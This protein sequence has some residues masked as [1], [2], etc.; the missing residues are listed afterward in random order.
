MEQTRTAS[1]DETWRRALVLGVMY[2]VVA[3]FANQLV[4]PPHPS[5][6]L[7]LPSG[8]ALAFLL[9][10]PPRR[11]PALLATVFVAEVASVLVHGFPLPF[12]VSGLWGLANC[13]RALT[14]AWLMRRFVGPDIRLSHR[15]EIAGLLF[16]GGLVS[17]LI[18]ATVGSFGYLFSIEPSSFWADWVNW[19]LSDGLGTIL[20]APLLLTWTPTALRSKR[21][22]CFVELGGLLGLTALGAH[23]L[24]GHATV[25][26]VWASMAYASFPFVLWG[27]LRMGPLG[28][29]STSAVVALFALWHTT[30]GQ[31]PF[32]TLVASLQ[33]RISSLQAFLAILGLTALTLA[34]VVSERWRTEELQHLRVEAGTVLAATLSIRESF[35]RL[36]HLVGS[37]M[38]MGC[39]VWLVD[40]N[41]LLERVA[42]AE[43][44]P[45]REARL[46]GHLPPLPTTLKHWRTPEG[47]AVLA[48]L[49]GRG[50]VQGGLVLMKD[51]SA[52]HAGAEDIALAEDLANQCSMA[53]ESAHLYAEAHQAIE[54]R[55][56]FITIAAHELRTPLTALSLHVQSLDALL[57]RENASEV[58]REKLRAT[59]R[60]VRRLS[61]L[62]ERV[63]DVG[64]ITSGRL[65]LHREE[66]DVGEWVEQVVGSFAEEAARADSAVRVELQAHVTA[67]WDRGRIEQAL[68]NLLANAIKFGAGHPIEVQVSRE[69]RWVRIAVRDHG[70]GIAPEARER[71]FERFERA[72]SSREYGGLGLG[73]FLTRQMVESHGGTIHVESHA[74]DGSTFV[75]QIPIGEQP[76]DEEEAS[77]S[78][79]A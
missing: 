14:G 46:R 36:A 57:R 15:W 65:E 75:L 1:W 40:E 30:L 78:A 4:F 19:W 77:R 63:L 56:E 12:W 71:I 79:P 54:A 76:A 43:W 21:W 48:P 61:Q 55:N 41:G 49:W 22:R 74:G 10:S 29:A 52:H 38:C 39:A 24:F 28:A 72:V 68:V 47:L 33:E 2:F 51:D 67:W 5:A 42:Q 6:V 50:A 45:A 34:A 69:G 8:I 16:F 27:A 3:N 66:V 23:F 31:G 26:G 64:R 7:W 44:S 37:R 73:L 32:G 35:P 58:A 20:V 9:R 18:S 62:V 60:Q 11:W 17:P 70:I 53:L 25:H 59:S 13:L